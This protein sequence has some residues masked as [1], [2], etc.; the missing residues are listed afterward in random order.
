[1]HHTQIGTRCQSELPR[2]AAGASGFGMGTGDQSPKGETSKAGWVLLGA[3]L[4]LAAGSIGYNVYEGSGG[5]SAPAAPADGTASIEQLRAAAEASKDDAGP[6]SDLAFAYFGQSNFPEAAAAYRRAL[7]IAP[8]EAVLWSALGETLVLAS[9][10]DPLP[11]DALAAFGKAV[12]LDPQ[13]PRA[14]Y[15]LAA[16]KDLDKD[17]EGA[18][19]AW[20]DLLADTPPG[21]PWEADLVRTIEQVGQMN[22][23]D[24]AARLAHRQPPL[25]EAAY[26]SSS[27]GLN[28]TA[29]IHQ[30]THEQTREDQL[31]RVPH[32]G[33]SSNQ[34]FFPGCVRLVV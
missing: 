30:V 25:R 2:L 28:P 21:A 14:R 18:I 33:P 29:S 17:H 12:S 34:G 23:I 5:A 6:W 19:A 32:E 31:R 27:S 11:A 4:L 15:F 26:I 8:D 10:R 7:E 9:Q 1:M 20:L 16:K 22:K 24:V 13:D 3:A